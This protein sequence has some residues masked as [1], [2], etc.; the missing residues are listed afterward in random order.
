MVIFSLLSI[1]PDHFQVA[2]VALSTVLIWNLVHAR[3]LFFHTR[4]NVLMEVWKLLWGVSV[5]FYGQYSS[6]CVVYRRPFHF[7]IAS[8]LQGTGWGSSM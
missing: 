4:Q 7:E 3:L 6:L 5:C 2:E 8:S 1:N